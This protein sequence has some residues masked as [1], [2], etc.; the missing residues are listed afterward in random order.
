MLGE[1]VRSEKCSE[2]HVARETVSYGGRYGRLEVGFRALGSDLTILPAGC[3]GMAGTYG[4]EVKH[5]ST[6]EDMCHELAHLA[7]SN[8]L[9]MDWSGA[10]GDRQETEGASPSR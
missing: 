10:P 6:S 1:R 3:C 2:V 5:W 8:L 4:H 7:S 9:M